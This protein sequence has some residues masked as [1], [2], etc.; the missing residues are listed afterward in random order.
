MQRPNCI[1]VDG[2]VVDIIARVIKPNIIVLG[3]VLSLSECEQLIGLA[4]PKLEKSTTT[5]PS[6]GLNREFERRTSR[7]AK[8]EPC[9]SPLISCIENRLANLAGIDVDNA[10]GLQVSHYALGEEYAPHFDFFPLG[11][12]SITDTV[13]KHGQRIATFLVYL[14]KVEDGGETVFPDLA[15]TV[16]AKQGGAVFFSYFDEYNNPDLRTLHAG[17]PI[18]DG[19]KWIATLWWR[20]RRY[21]KC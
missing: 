19:E 9:E 7:S 16:S 21:R 4:R 10:E 20:E 3:N 12:A 18:L 13:K 15:F 14:N 8:F 6:T 1:T 2:Q 11:S 5:D 17:A